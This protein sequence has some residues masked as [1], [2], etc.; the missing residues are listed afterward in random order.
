MQI[1]LWKSLQLHAQEPTLRQRL[2]NLIAQFEQNSALF[3]PLS[4]RDRFDA[5]DRLDALLGDDV[6][7]SA[8]ATAVDPAALHRAQS[9]RHR[10]E[11]INAELSQSIRV[12]IRQGTRPALFAQWLQ[13]N[14]VPAPGLSFDSLDEILSV[15]LALEEPDPPPAHPPDGMVFYQPTPARHIFHL[16]HLATLSTTDVLIDLGSGLGHVPLMASLCTGARS[17]G[18]EREATY[19]A[20]A[21]HCARQ[22]NLD[23][24]SFLQ[25]DAREA[26]LSSG[27]VFYLYTPFTGPILAAV[28]H[29]L[30]QQSAQRPI[31]ICTFGPCTQAVAQEPWLETSAHPDTDQVTLFSSRA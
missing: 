26:D 22:L 17:I 18:I 14:L 25:Q 11:A 27:T 6:A 8:A 31:R 30:R 9:L 7:S 20:S 23:R 4:L 28:L 12:E 1:V 21:E 16:L 13:S 5:L 19:V 24:V 29:R 15:V 3:E 10:L 2:E